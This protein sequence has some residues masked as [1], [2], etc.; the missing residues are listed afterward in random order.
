MRGLRKFSESI[1]AKAAYLSAK[2]KMDSRTV[3]NPFPVPKTGL[4]V[5]GSE[6]LVA[7]LLVSFGRFQLHIYICIDIF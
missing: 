6:D 2:E 7:R 5:R 3:P 1:W 4:T